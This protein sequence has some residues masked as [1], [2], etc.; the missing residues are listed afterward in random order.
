MPGYVPTNVHFPGSIPLPDAPAVFERLS[1]ALPS[2]IC[3]LPDGE[4]GR[5]NYFVLF[6]EEVFS[7]SPWVLRPSRPL[8][9]INSEG[10]KPP[11]NGEIVLGPIRYDDLAIASYKQFCEARVAGIVKEGVRFQVSLPTPAN[12]ISALIDPMWQAKVEPVYEDAM[13][14]A[15]RRIQMKIPGQ[16]LAIQWDAAI[17]F[18][19]LEGV[20]V[21]TPPWLLEVEDGRMSMKEA[22]LKRLLKVANAVDGEDVELGFHLC[23]GDIRHKHFVEPKDL[24]LL[25]EVADGILRGANRP[26]AFLHMPVP[27]DRADA[28]YYAP[29][30]ELEL[31]STALVLGLLHR[32][33]DEGTRQRIEA[34]SQVVRAFGIATECGLGRA[35]EEE[36][37]SI[38][39]IARDVMDPN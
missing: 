2:S 36:L 32:D 22:V 37:N 7:P 38:L 29:L 1:H 35:S 10:S 25:V 31:G 30:K 16:D 20:E 21:W 33:D 15:V 8:A 28:S 18:A 17:E 39:K 11:P 5:R 26:V 23:Y 27:R 3:R 34:A 24:G 19:W 6:Q 9:T 13:I 12:V 14:A 4:T